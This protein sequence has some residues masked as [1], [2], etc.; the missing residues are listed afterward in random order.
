MLG[1]NCV[2]L[3]RKER[4][5]VNEEFLVDVPFFVKY[6]AGFGQIINAS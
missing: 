6:F 3:A 4:E 5:V 1:D 2:G